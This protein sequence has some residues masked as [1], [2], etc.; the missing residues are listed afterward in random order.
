M[1]MHIELSLK[2]IRLVWPVVK[3]K[4]YVQDK[5][6]QD[7]TALRQMLEQGAQILVCGGRDM[8]NGVSQAMND[9][10]KPLQTN[11]EALK[12]QGRYL[13]DVY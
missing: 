7:Q 10:L 2:A 8:A 3:E 12:A 4:N 11:V 1:W 5:L 9:I 13:E 6:L